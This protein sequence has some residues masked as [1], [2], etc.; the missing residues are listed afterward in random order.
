MKENSKKD[1]KISLFSPF[2]SVYSAYG[3]RLI[4]S[5]LVKR[6]FSVKVYYYPQDF[7]IRYDYSTLEMI[8]S[9]LL[10]SDIV[11]IS[12]FTN[13]FN[14]ALQLTRYLKDK[15]PDLLVV[16]GGVHPTIRPSEC[17]KFA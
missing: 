1:L 2:N 6:G 16:W 14:N 13:H 7:R 10:D 5:S 3:L 8:S 17:I 4:Y 9:F 11:G 12:L 15:K